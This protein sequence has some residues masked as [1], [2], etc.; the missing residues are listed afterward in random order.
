VWEQI[1]LVLIAG[2]LSLGGVLYTQY[3]ADVR[4]REERDK[5]VERERELWARE[6]ELRSYEHR[7]EAYENFV[8]EWFRHYD[9]AF[10][11]KV[12]H[13][14]EPDPVQLPYDFLDPLMSKALVRVHMYGSHDASLHANEAANNLLDYVLENVEIQH[15]PISRFQATVRQELGIPGS[16]PATAGHPSHE[17]DSGGTHGPQFGPQTTENE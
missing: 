10:A 4:S 17:S 7:R 1:W 12:E 6:D 2:G 13:D 11:Y 8:M 16:N 3:R 9:L 5:G 15:D 14:G